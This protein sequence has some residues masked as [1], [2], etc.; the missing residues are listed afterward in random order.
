VSWIVGGDVQNSLQVRNR[1]MKAGS[2]LAARVAEY[3]ESPRVRA[4]I[5]RETTNWME[6][7]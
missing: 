2:P 4:G 7:T 5:D 1:E 6:R 3:K